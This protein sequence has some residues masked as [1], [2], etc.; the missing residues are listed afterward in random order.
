MQTQYLYALLSIMLFGGLGQHLARKRNRNGIPW[1]V[2]A[3]LFPPVL[4]VLL[5]LKPADPEEEEGS[6]LSEG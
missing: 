6:E 3:A 2:G 4:L 1:G 5:L